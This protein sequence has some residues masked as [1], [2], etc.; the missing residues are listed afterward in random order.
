MSSS[1]KSLKLFSY[2]SLDNYIQ[3]ACTKDMMYYLVGIINLVMVCG[4]TYW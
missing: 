2:P 1:K 3:H 4:T